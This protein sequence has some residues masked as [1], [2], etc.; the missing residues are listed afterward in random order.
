MS[1]NLEAEKL[2][3]PTINGSIMRTHLAEYNNHTDD[4]NDLI[5]RV[6]KVRNNLMGPCV[7]STDTVEPPASADCTL[8]ELRAG[9]YCFKKLLYTLVAEVEALEQI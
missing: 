2:G 1:K 7:V 6:A 4:L 5:Q 9:N 3:V 8:D